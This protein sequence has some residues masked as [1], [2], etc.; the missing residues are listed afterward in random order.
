MNFSASADDSFSSVCL[1]LFVIHVRRLSQNFFEEIN[2][3]RKKKSILSFEGN[4]WVFE[5]SHSKKMAPP[6]PPPLI[7][8]SDSD[9]EDRKPNFGDRRS[10]FEDRRSNYGERRPSQVKKEPRNGE[11]TLEEQ[12]HKQTFHVILYSGKWQCPFFNVIINRLR[13]WFSLWQLKFV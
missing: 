10:N 1:C 5:F 4:F 12:Q 6:H 13:L 2:F 7:E 8:L 9:N 3:W 11:G